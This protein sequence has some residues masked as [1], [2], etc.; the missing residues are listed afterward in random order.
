MLE[1]EDV[2]Q[3][4]AAPAVDRLIGV[5]DDRQVA[6]ALGQPLD[7]MVL[8][9]VRVLILVDHDEAELLGI[10]RRAHARLVEQFDS[11]QQQIVEVERAVLLEALR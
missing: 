8:R 6:M 7:Q 5:A 3:I 11:L 9:P 1:V 2:A 10:L 4:G